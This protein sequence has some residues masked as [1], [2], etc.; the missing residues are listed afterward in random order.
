MQDQ[1]ILQPAQQSAS[2]TMS[3]EI[4]SGPI[5]PPPYEPRTKYE[6]FP[7]ITA[8]WLGLILLFFG[9][10]IIILNVVDILLNHLFGFFGQGMLAGIFVRMSF[11]YC[12]KKY[13][14]ASLSWLYRDHL[15]LYLCL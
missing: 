14:L 6:S 12:V 10:V 13:L 5:A 8:F 9:I 3:G 11:L 1:T 7:A 15:S 2:E 4:A